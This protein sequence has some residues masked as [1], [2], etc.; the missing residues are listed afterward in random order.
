VVHVAN[1]V[2]LDPNPNVVIPYTIDAIENIL[3]SSSQEPLVKRFVLTSSSLAAYSPVRGMRRTLTTESWNE[4]LVLSA[5][6]PPPYEASRGLAVYGASKVQGEQALW[7]WV[8]ANNPDMVVNSSTFG[9]TTKNFLT[10]SMLVL[11]CWILGKVLDPPNQGFPSSTGLFKIIFDGNVE[12]YK[13]LI[14]PRKHQLSALYHYV[15]LTNLQEYTVDVQDVARLHVGALLLP[16][17]Q[18]ERIFAWATRFNINSQLAV[19]RKVFPERSFPENQPD[20]WDDLTTAPTGRAEQILQEMG[21][22][23]WTTEEE[24]WDRMRELFMR[25]D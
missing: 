8:E 23:R 21:V 3:Q 25:N 20:E 11:P 10:Y 22:E 1:N 16:D 9:I 12:L 6:E 18:N 24:S 2:S 17:V 14:V 13:S 15:L 7:N 4:K 5:W 19:V